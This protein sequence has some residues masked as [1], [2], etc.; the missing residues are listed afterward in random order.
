MKIHDVFHV[1]LLKPASTDP[2]PGQAIPNPLPV[3]ID[4]EEE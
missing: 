3:E 4:G 2:F 1:N